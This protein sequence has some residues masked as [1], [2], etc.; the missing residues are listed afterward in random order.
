MVWTIC[1]ECHRVWTTR[2][3]LA[4]CGAGV[5]DATAKRVIEVSMNCHGR[6]IVHADQAACWAAH[7]I[8]GPEAV[9]AMLLE[10]VVRDPL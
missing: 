8:G 5:Y 1:V 4:V 2:F 6:R 7:A 10:L 9:T 3:P